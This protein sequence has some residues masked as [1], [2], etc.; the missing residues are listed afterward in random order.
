MNG[1]VL[2]ACLVLVVQID[3]ENTSVAL[4]EFQKYD[5]YKINNFCLKSAKV[6]TN[7]QEI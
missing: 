3:I 7:S 5:P 6:L 4:Q 2:H 1:V